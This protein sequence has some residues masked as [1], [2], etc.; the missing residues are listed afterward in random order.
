MSQNYSC[1]YQVTVGSILSDS[2]SKISCLIFPYPEAVSDNT[3][4]DVISFENC[5]FPSLV[6]TNTME[7]Y[8]N[9]TSD[10]RIF[11]HIINTTPKLTLSF[12]NRVT[13]DIS[14]GGDGIVCNISCNFNVWEVL[15]H[16]CSRYYDLAAL[17]QGRLPVCHNRNYS[18]SIN[19]TFDTGIIYL[20][21]EPQII[22]QCRGKSS[23]LHGMYTKL[24]MACIDCTFGCVHPSALMK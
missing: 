4:V 14:I 6:L 7:Q 18:V 20:N 21:D 24:T 19:I 8:Q 13:L 17:I 23:L 3:W 11:K 10:C 16:N 15:H 2:V 5:E 12:V 22:N 1:H 9:R